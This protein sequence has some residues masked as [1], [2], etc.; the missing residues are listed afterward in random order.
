MILKLDDDNGDDDDGDDGLAV[1]FNCEQMS[2]AL[3]VS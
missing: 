1:C 2:R 3:G